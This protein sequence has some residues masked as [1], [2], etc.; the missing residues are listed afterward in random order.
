MLGDESRPSCHHGS[1]GSIHRGC[2]GLHLIKVGSLSNNDF[3][4]ISIGILLCQQGTNQ[5]NVELFLYEPF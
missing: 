4:S 2:L 3:D 1:F 5:S